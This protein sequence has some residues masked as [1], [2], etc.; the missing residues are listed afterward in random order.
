MFHSMRAAAV[1]LATAA[2]A[3]AFIDDDGDRKIADYDR[4]DSFIL[5][6]RGGEGVF[7]CLLL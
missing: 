2:A 1:P 6:D 4:Q 7:E 5:S 3:A